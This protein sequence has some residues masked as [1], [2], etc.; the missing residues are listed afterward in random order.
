MLCGAHESDLFHKDTR[1][2]YYRCGECALVFVPPQERLSLEDERARYDTHNNDPFE[3]G[4]RAFVG[5]IIPP[6]TAGLPKGSA[7]L[8]F[9]SGPDSSGGSALSLQLGEQGYPTRVYDPLYVPDSSVFAERYDFVVLTEVLEH[10]FALQVLKELVSL[11]KESGRLGVMTKL[12]RD[13]AAFT[14]WHYIRDP[15]H[16]CFFSRETFTWVAEQLHLSLDYHGQDMVILRRTV[17]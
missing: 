11:L 12:V 6:L 14:T 4:Y 15:T 16:V 10:L 2:H 13:Q 7:G 3:P 5:R 9:G 1:R 8:D 17:K